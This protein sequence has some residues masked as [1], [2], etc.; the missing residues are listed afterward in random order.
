VGSGAPPEPRNG[1]YRHGLHTKVAIAER[2]FMR[3]LHRQSRELL[4][5][6][7]AR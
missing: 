6:V 7:E 2:Q 1:N 3:A 4:K 5:H